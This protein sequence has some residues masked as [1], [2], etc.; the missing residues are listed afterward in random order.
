MKTC[1]EAILKR[2]PDFKLF[3][4][5]V[6]SAMLAG[7]CAHYPVNAPLT[8][9]KP[10]AGY[11]FENVTQTN[12]D[13]TSLVLAFS[14]GGTRAAALSYGVLQA[15]A[16]TEVGQPSQEHRLLDDVRMVSAV[17]GGSITA[18]YYTLYGDRIFSDYESRFLK[19]HVQNG[20][21]LRLVA[22]WNLARLSS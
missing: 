10:A 20:L 3:G 17:S 14:G 19:R 11:R 13:D 6:L 9:V 16:K 12:T 7:G 21:F 4:L 22:P 15:L 2:L 8:A 18:A 5:L 1:A